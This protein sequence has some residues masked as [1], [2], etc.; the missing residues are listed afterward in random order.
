MIQTQAK[1]EV[2][3]ETPIDTVK[4]KLSKSDEVEAHIVK[5][6]TENYNY[7]LESHVREAVSNH[8]DSHVENGTPDNPIFVKLYSDGTGNYVLETSDTG[9]GLTEEEF[10]KYYMQVGESSKRG[11]AN[12]IGGKG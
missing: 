6:L 11:K 10:D 12:L 7:P 4:M 1:R 2:F 8:W 9:L 3:I 5:I